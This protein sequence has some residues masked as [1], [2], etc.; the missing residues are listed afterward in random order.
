MD[1]LKTYISEMLRVLIRL[2]AIGGCQSNRIVFFSYFGKQYSCNPM[3]ISEYIQKNYP[4]TDIVWAFND[5]EAYAYLEKSGI[6]VVKYNSLR[7]LRILMTSGTI[8]TNS[9]VPSWWAFGNKQ[10]Y[11]NTWHGG[12]AYKRVGISYQKETAG[13]QKRGTI[14]HRN[15]CVYLSSSEAFTRQTI[16]E[17]FEHT[18]EVLECGMPRN[19]CLVNQEFEKAGEKVRTACGISSDTRI[20]LYAPTYRE[21]KDAAEYELDCTCLKKALSERFGGKWVILYRMHYAVMNSLRGSAEYL[22]VSGY[23]RMQELLCAAEFLITDYSSCMWDYALSGKPGMLYTTDL[24]LY[25]MERG[26]YSDIHTWPFALAQS[27]EELEKA[28]LTYDEE[29]GKARAERHLRNLGSCETGRATEAVSEYIM[30]YVK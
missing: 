27:H 6:K 13:K 14:A 26:F 1:K 4:R 12:G 3:Y 24:A 20:C 15:K 7:F 5:P 10:L 21:S 29:D 28:I 30:K 11:I 9:E 8:V 2:L 25:D 17:S 22:D 16:R 19:D 23:P 18:G